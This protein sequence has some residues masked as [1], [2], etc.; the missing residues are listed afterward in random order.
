LRR[1]QKE[2]SETA[3]GAPRLDSKQ[4][5]RP[6]FQQK[7]ENAAPP[8]NKGD[9]FNR[10]V[11]FADAILGLIKA[12]TVSSV[13][14]SV[15]NDAKFHLQ[16]TNVKINLAVINVSFDG[17]A[18]NDFDLQYRIGELRA[19]RD[20]IYA[21]AKK[22]FSDNET[23][24][25]WKTE[26]KGLEYKLRVDLYNDGKAYTPFTIPR[27]KWLKINGKGQPI[28]HNENAITALKYH[29]EDEEIT[30]A[31]D[32]WKNSISVT[33]LKKS[34]FPRESKDFIVKNYINQLVG[35]FNI[36]FT[37]EEIKFGL[38]QLAANNA[39]H[40]MLDYFD[41]SKWDGTP[42][43]MKLLTEIMN[44]EADND[45]FQLSV[46][47]KQ[48]V[49]SVRR[50]RFPGAKYDMC[51]L[52][53]ATEGWNKSTFLI[54]LYGRRNV[55]SEDILDL[56]T[57]E[58]SEKLR[59]G[60]MA[61]EL[62]DT[63]GDEKKSDARKIKAFITRQDDVGRDAYGR[64]EDVEHIGRTCVYWHTGNNPYLLISEEGNRRFIPFYIMGVMNIDLLRQEKDQIWAEVV[65]LEREGRLKYEAEMRTKNIPIN[66]DDEVYPDIMLE[67]KYWQK[68][69][70]LQ[71]QAKKKTGYEELL[72]HVLFW[73][74]V[75]WQAPKDGFAKISIFSSDIKSRLEIPNYK[76][77]GEAQKISKI[78]KSKVELCQ[79]ECDGLLGDISWFKVVNL[80][81]SVNNI[82]L[83]GYTIEFSGEVGLR[84]YQILR[85]RKDEWD[86]PMGLI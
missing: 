21:I 26:I 27:G 6:A 81:K 80:K 14:A 68:A 77:N 7:A 83:N 61:V 58:Q 69:T 16:T 64:V 32:H 57:K 63:L 39:R 50:V 25:G 82:P 31:Y 9:E 56:T 44:I 34:K 1:Q 38:G 76:W 51:P 40:S 84:S 54:V 41:Q 22:L 15:V 28:P 59:N 45:G 72:S 12:A 52:L 73:P 43:L 20:E 33:N 19:K 10:N 62:A 85:K 2:E 86:N 55:L 5:E 70:T 42:R 79:L 30:V 60:I 18:P 36:L 17:A 23:Y 78:M 71:N 67:K 48:L 74:E 4:A 37:M 11:T 24:K 35:K 66:L 3:H 75:Y 13:P 53:I 8:E 47:T 46:I 49:A 29:F 65:E